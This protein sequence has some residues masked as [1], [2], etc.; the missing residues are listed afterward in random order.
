MHQANDDVAVAIADLTAGTEVRV[1]TIEGEEV[2]TLTVIEDIP[3]GHK[4][5]VNDIAEG[6]DVIKY[7][8]SIGR[9][10]RTIPRGAHVHVHN[11]KS[12]RWA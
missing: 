2:S 7:G 11:I 10:I 3:L 6:K 5:A 4:F 8:R 9:A 12:R 1:M